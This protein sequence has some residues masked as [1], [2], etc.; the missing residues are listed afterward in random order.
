MVPSIL[1]ELPR[2]LA[3]DRLTGPGNRLLAFAGL[4]RVRLYRG[5]QDDLAADGRGPTPL[6]GDWNRK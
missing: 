4:A 1:A 3:S 2:I 5:A 6:S